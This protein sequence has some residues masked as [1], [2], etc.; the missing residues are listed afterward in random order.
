[1]AQHLEQGAALLDEVQN[2]EALMLAASKSVDVVSVIARQAGQLGVPLPPEVIDAIPALH[3]WATRAKQQL[4][5]IHQQ[6]DEAL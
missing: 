3:D 1:M 2:I 5:L 4:R 6:Q